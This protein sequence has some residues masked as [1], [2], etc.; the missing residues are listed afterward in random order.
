MRISFQ[1]SV[2]KNWVILKVGNPAL[3]SL[4]HSLIYPLPLTLSK[5]TSLRLKRLKNHLMLS[6][7]LDLLSRLE[8][9]AH[10][11]LV[12]KV[13]LKTYKWVEVGNL[14]KVGNLPSPSAICLSLSL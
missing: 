1:L 13:S 3:L 5:E 14:P 12:S 7:S 10:L 2:T 9:G 6:P 8:P 11:S 4:L